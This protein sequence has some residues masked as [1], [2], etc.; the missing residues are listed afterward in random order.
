MFRLRQMRVCPDELQFLAVA[1]KFP[2]ERNFSPGVSAAE[3]ASRQVHADDAR[4][5]WRKRAQKKKRTSIIRADFQAAH[6]RVSL[7]QFSQLR[8]FRAHLR[9]D[10]GAIGT[11]INGCFG[12]LRPPGKTELAVKLEISNALQK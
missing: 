11:K 4:T 8:D 1:R 2:V 10:N 9:D 7:Q 5:G 3:P 6:G 12:S